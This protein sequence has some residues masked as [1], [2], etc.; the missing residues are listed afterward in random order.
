M[1]VQ[2][3]LYTIHVNDKDIVIIGVHLLA[4]PNNQDRKAEREAQADVI[5]K[6]VVEQSDSLSE[7][8][9]WGDCNDFDPDCPDIASDMPIT[10]VLTQLKEMRPA[11]V[12]DNLV[13]V[14][15]EK[16][17]PQNLRYTSWWDKNQNGIADQGEFSSIDHVLISPGLARYLQSVDII[18]SYNPA[19]VSDH[20]PI[21]ATFDFSAA[22]STGAPSRSTLYISKVLPNP[23]GN[24]SELEAVWLTNP[25]SSD[26]TLSGWKL[27]DKAG[28]SW[29]L[30]R[31]G[32]VKVGET[33]K[34]L[35]GKRPMSLNNTGDL[36][37]LV[38]PNG[39]VVSVVTFGPSDT[40]EILEF[41]Q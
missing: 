22:E 12:S 33:K 5:R 36:L 15:C 41:T 1:S 30:A 26:I 11:D 16:Q 14:I 13:S 4:Q 9:I 40:D 38:D 35:R 3:L 7:T 23:D 28:K 18:H 17:Y 31:D 37:E 6:L 29:D 24:E 25:G 39:L 27:R 21:V 20:F 19:E 8:V 34:I 32:K 10:T 2:A